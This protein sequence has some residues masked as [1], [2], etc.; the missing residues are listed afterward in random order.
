MRAIA[1]R[2]E[3][4]PEQGPLAQLKAVDAAAVLVETGVG[5]NRAK[6]AESIAQGIERYVREK[7]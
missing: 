6:A 7:R 5:L 4:E 2:G 1:A 3:S